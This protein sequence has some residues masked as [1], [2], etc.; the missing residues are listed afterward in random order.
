VVE[1]RNGFLVAPGDMQRAADR[2]L[3][4]L[5]DAELRQ[6][7]GRA[8]QAAAEEFDSRTMLRQQEQLYSGFLAGATAPRR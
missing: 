6:R 4:L 2:V 3:A 5:A 1:G 8:G 7:F